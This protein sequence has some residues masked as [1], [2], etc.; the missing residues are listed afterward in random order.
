WLLGFCLLCALIIVIVRWRTRRFQ[1][2]QDNLEKQIAEKTWQLQVKNEELEKTD[3]IKT[4][5]ISI[6]SH[7][8]VTPLRFLHLTGKN[9]VENRNGLPEALRQEAIGEMATTSKDLELLSTN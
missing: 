3:L 9:L 5:L 1:I 2:R 8:L 6:I 4:R 7:D